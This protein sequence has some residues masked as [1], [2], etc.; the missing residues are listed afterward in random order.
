MIHK[1]HR[2]VY[3]I[4][5][6]PLL[7]F[8]TSEA[9]AE[10][11]V[12]GA[13]AAGDVLIDVLSCMIVRADEDGSVHTTAHHGMPMLL[14]PANIALEHSVGCGPVSPVVA[15]VRDEAIASVGSRVSVGMGWMTVAMLIPVAAAY[16]L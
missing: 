10:W 9:E 15:M 12:F 3:A 14:M 5:R 7:A 13:H 11:R 1:L 2:H 16:I 8:M 6:P 4:Y